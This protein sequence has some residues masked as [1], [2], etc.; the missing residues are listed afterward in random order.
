MTTRTGSSI[1]GVVEIGAGSSRNRA[2]LERQVLFEVLNALNATPNLDELL[3]RVHASLQKVLSA[4]NCY[5]ALHDSRTGTFHYPFFVDRF[6][7]PPSP[8][9]TGRT[10]AA[11]VFRTGRSMHITKEVF[12]QLEAAGEVDRIGT[13]SRAW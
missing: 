9:T 7:V 4:D 2:G 13:P 11:Y 6:D 8:R 10:L 5:V 12:A 1:S 3:A